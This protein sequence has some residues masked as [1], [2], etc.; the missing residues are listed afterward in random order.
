MEVAFRSLF[1]I[2]LSFNFKESGW[3]MRAYWFRICYFFRNFELKTFEAVIIILLTTV[4]SVWVQQ[5]MYCVGS[6]AGVFMI[7]IKLL[8]Q[9]CVNFLIIR[10][11]HETSQIQPPPPPSI[12]TL[13]HRY[14]SAKSCACTVETARCKQTKHCQ[15]LTEDSLL[16]PP[17]RLLGFGP[18]KHTVH[19][20]MFF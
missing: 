4:G 7:F 2:T 11:Y 15:A 8:L 1:A 5:L 18:I 6:E 12:F 9:G 19:E 20:I 3:T 16:Y 10:R 14:Y 13:S 17:F